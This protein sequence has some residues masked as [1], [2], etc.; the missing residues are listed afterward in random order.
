MRR[1]KMQVVFGTDVRMVGSLLG[2]REDAIGV[3]FKRV[4]LGGR[5]T[6]HCFDTMQQLSKAADV[7]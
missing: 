7:H 5:G 2:E 3:G 1:P 6:G 4:G